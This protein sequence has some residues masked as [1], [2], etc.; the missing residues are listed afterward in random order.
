MSL[1]PAQL[2]GVFSWATAITANSDFEYEE[3]LT[4]IK[5]ES[6][7][8]FMKFELGAFNA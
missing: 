7:Q 1:D 5:D 8:K 6:I 3:L 2:L 4:W